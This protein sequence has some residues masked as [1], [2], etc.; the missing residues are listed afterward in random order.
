ML[1]F[2]KGTVP[3][4]GKY[5]KSLSC[6]ILY[7]TIDVVLKPEVLN[8]AANSWLSYFS[9]ALVSYLACTEKKKTVNKQLF[10]GSR[11]ARK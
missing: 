2:F 8:P 6:Q 10:S 11:G 9:L 5:I 3:H 1:R 7:E 4:F